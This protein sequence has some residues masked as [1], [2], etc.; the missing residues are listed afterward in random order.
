MSNPA[1]VYVSVSLISSDLIKIANQTFYGTF[2][3]CFDLLSYY[4]LCIG[5]VFVR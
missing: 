1:I 5:F 3:I 2:Q 4:T